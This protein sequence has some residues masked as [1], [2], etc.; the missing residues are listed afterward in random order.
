MICKCCGEVKADW[1]N[2]KY[3][4]ECWAEMFGEEREMRVS[5]ASLEEYYDNMGDY[6]GEDE[7]GND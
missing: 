3:C 4:R 1:G 5:R 6:V 2:K 7:N